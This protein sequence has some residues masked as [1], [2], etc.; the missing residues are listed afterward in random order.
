MMTIRPGMK[1]LRTR[2]GIEEHARAGLDRQLPI[3]EDL[4]ERFEEGDRVADI[5]GEAAMLDSV[6]STRTRICAVSPACSLRE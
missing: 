5:D 1:K 6:P 2:V 4:L 3:A